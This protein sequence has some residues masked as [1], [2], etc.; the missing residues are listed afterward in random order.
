MIFT[1]SQI[2]SALKDSKLTF[3]NVL[4][5]LVILLLVAC[6]SETKQSF[7][8]PV[9]ASLLEDCA[10]EL[11]IEEVSSADY[12]ARFVSSDTL[13]PNE[14]CASYWARLVFEE[15]MVGEQYVLPRMHVD[16]IF[17]YVQQPDGSFLTDITGEN[18]AMKYRSVR[19]GE[20]PV[21]LFEVPQSKVLYLKLESAS[22]YSRGFRDLKGFTIEPA[23]KFNSKIYGSRYFHGIFFGV[24]M[25]MIIYN[26][27]IYIMNRDRAYLV[28]IIFMITQTIYQLSITGFLRELI[29]PD[30]PILAKYS[31]FVTAG[32]S[33]M[34]Y[35]WFSQVYLEAK[36][37]ARKLNSLLNALYVIIALTIIIGLFYKMATA[38]AVLLIN[39]LLVTTFAFIVAIIAFR[40]NFVPAKFFLISGVLSFVGYYLFTMQ[41][42]ELLPTVFITRYSLQITFALQGLLFALGLG[43]RMNRIQTELN[44]N[45][46]RQAELKSERERELKNILERQNIVLE[47]KV[48]ERTSELVE[49]SEIIERDR[50]IIQEERQKS[51]LLL[52]NILPESI[53]ERL[54]GGEKMIADQFEDV[55]VFFSDIVG[56]TS[57]SKRMRPND[58]VNLLNEVF[59][60]FDKLAKKY[61]LEK[62]KT[63]GDSYM[64]V[65]GLPKVS[66]DHAMRMANFACDVLEVINIINQKVDESLSVRIGIHSGPV[67]AG[68]IGSSKIAY[69]LWGETVNVASRLESHGETM[70]ICC[71]QEFKA[72]ISGDFV[73][74][75]FG[76]VELK[77]IGKTHVFQMRR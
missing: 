15:S 47:Q 18:V 57:F 60:E 7:I 21:V 37:F 35:I 17:S 23:S 33:L 16:S 9:E 56:F 25:A 3:R 41:G 73:F 2:N 70:K 36:R 61:G 67:V 6:S 38:N 43:D 74:K 63:I 49:K 68:V 45:K 12:V 72:Q 55:S 14:N 69:D 53:A 77:G 76:E 40:K 10:N 44:F 22:L 52:L 66:S 30:L 59:S 24:M 39:G 54:K 26:I 46:I 1:F 65:S 5:G 28:F 29:L 42:L 8:Y 71:S 34:S 13:E 11:S 62:I 32:I 48:A 31:P 4:L 50:A 64:C 27:F 51:D 19:Y 58:L 20:L 75:D